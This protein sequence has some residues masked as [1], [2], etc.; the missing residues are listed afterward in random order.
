MVEDTIQS[1]KASKTMLI[2]KTL[3]LKISADMH[4]VNVS[5]EGER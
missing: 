4:V 2:I 1:H 3:K 5:R